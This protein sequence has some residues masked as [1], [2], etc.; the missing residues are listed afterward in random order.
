[1]ALGGLFEPAH[2]TSA[3]GGKADIGRNVSTS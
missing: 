2:L 1:M 3:F